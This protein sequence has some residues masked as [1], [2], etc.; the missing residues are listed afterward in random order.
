MEV[1][2]GV[3]RFRIDGQHKRARAATMTL[4]HGEVQTPVFMPV[5]T[6]GS[7]KG[8]T[9]E[10]VGEG[11][12]G[13]QI[14]LGNTYH[15]GHRPGGDAVERLGGLH[16]MMGWRGNLL[17]DS[18]GFQMVSLLKLAQVTEEGVTF[19]SPHDGS[20]MVLSPEHS[21]R[22]QH[23]IGSDIVMQLDDVVSSMERGP[24]L[25]EAM[26][27]SVR[28][29]D[30][31]VAAHAPRAHCQ[32][33]FAIIQGGLDPALRVRCVEEMTK[34]DVP[35]F[36][37]GGLSGGEAKVSASKLLSVLMFRAQDEFWRM[38]HLV[39]PLLP[40]NKPRY[41]MGIGYA[42]DLVVCTALGCDMYDCVFPTRTAR[43]GTALTF[44]GPLNLKQ[45]QFAADLAPLDP[46]CRCPVC[47]RYSRA[48]LHRGA[49]KAPEAGQLLSLH[50][51]FFQKD[52][53]GRQRAAILA[54]CYDEWVRGFLQTRFQ[55]DTPQWVLEALTAAGIDLALQ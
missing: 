43:F 22:L 11:G 10:Q 15:L 49:G 33:L 29:L 38:V 31:C 47:A 39:A 35:G 36:A 6:Q 40:A 41:V 7:I 37:I 23:Q 54:G 28:W 53:M 50:N 48:F 55:G 17:T 19:Q 8:L 25:E 32:N 44:A 14:I 13:V 52:L 45:A 30:R 51:L 21:V 5:G 12:L 16:R 18:G 27:R 1:P 9:C 26:L 46:S 20:R 24:R 42:E 2:N 4:G 34:R 3:L